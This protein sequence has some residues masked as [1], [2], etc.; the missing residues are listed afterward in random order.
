MAE[1]RSFLVMPID[2]DMPAEELGRILE[3]IAAA[4]PGLFGPSDVAAAISKNGSAVLRV[5]AAAVDTVKDMLG[6]RFIFE[7]NARLHY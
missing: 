5:P 7:P 6:N 2:A 4:V 3:Q 1:T